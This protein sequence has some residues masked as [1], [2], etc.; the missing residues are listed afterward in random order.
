MARPRRK[1]GGQFRKLREQK[2]RATPF[3]TYRIHPKC[4]TGGHPLQLHH[5]QPDGPD[6]WEN[7]AVACMWCN[8][9]LRRRAKHRKRREPLW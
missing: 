4:S 1:Y 2:L 9:K 5:I 6:S 3:C 7:T 8:N